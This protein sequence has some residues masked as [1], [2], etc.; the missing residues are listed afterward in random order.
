MANIEE[1]FDINEDIRNFM[2]CFEGFE[3]FRRIPFYAQLLD[4]NT[5]ES[6]SQEEPRISEIP[7]ESTCGESMEDD[8][9]QNLLWL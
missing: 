6:N 2:R 8:L 9:F 5:I 7:I 4:L 3:S 1:M